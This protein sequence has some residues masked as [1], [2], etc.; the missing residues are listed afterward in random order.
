MRKFLDCD[1]LF[2]QSRPGLSRPSMP[3][4]LKFGKKDVDDRDKRGH[5]RGER[6]PIAL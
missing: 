6:D 2:L 4:L 3:C 1:Q 5:G